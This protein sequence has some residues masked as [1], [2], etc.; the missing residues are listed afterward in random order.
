LP[1]K[2]N[3][4]RK[5]FLRSP[6][7][8]MPKPLIALP[9][10]HITHKG[11]VPDYE[12]N[13]MYIKAVIAARGFPI[14]VPSNIPKSDWQMLIDTFDGFLFSGGGD[15]DPLHYDGKV[16]ANSYGFS[17]E[18]DRF[19][20]GLVPLVLKADKPLLG[21]CRGTQVLNVALGG[22]LV[23]DIATELT[24]AA[25]HD[26]FPNYARDK[27]VHQVTVFPETKLFDLMGQMKVSTNS[28]HHQAIKNLGQGL[29]L[30]AAA[31]DGVVEGVE[32]PGK[33]FVVGVQWHP[34]HLQDDHG[35]R[36]LFEGFI[37]AAGAK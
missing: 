6:E 17:E 31:E 8:I 29:V 26:W 24:E 14:I 11:R 25:K 36:A 19:E 4:N 34:E 18:R 23:G 33:R 7:E 22:T 5:G 32:M 9:A 27:R 37:E 15:I 2:I 16:A 28:L 21:I 30:S 3:L 35:M 1:D 10:A 20:L 12:I 13:E